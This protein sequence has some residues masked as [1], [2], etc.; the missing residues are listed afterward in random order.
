MKRRSKEKRN[1]GIS[2]EVERDKTDKNQQKK[3]IKIF[4]EFSF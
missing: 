3:E 1:T 2:K 4:I